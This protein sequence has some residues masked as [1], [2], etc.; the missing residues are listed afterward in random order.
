MAIG[1]ITGTG[2]HALPGFQG[3]LR[4]VSTPWGEIDATVGAYAGVDAV[5]ISRHGAGHVRLT[6]PGTNLKPPYRPVPVYP[7]LLSLG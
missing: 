5:H 2:T 6:A 1:I 3:E 7:P 4:T